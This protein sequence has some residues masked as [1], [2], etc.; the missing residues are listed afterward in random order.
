MSF[1]VSCLHAVTVE[2]A[3]VSCKGWEEQL[4]LLLA[5][6]GDGVPVTVLEA[7]MSSG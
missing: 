3:A 2:G 1:C 6:H 4:L 7:S 5:L